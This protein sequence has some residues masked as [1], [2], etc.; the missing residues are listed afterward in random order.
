MAATKSLLNTPLDTTPD[1]ELSVNR[2]AW[3]AKAGELLVDALNRYAKA[4]ATKQVP[5]V[6]YLPRWGRS[7]AAIPA[8]CR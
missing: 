5:Q 4:T 3:P 6:C 8:W 7:R 1:T 2:K